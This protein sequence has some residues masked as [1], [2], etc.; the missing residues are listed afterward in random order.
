M[1][2]KRIIRNHGAKTIIAETNSYLTNG[3]RMYPFHELE[4]NIL[5]IFRDVKNFQKDL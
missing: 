1:N 5:K 4:K 2:Y 3:E